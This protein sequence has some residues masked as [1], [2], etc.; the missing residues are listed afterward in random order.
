MADF[1][2]S[3]PVRTESNGDIVAKIGDKTTPSQQL[4]IDAAGLIGGKVY[5]GG[6]TAIGNNGTGAALNVFVTSVP[7]LTADTSTFTYAT[8]T[9]QVVGAVFQ[10]TGATIAAGK[11]GALRMTAQRG[12]HSNLR[13][14]SGNELL[15]SKVSASSVPVVVA[16]DNTLTVQDLAD[17][18]VAPG[19]V[20]TKSLLTGGQFNTTLPT[21][22]TG[23]QAAVQVDSSGRVLVAQPT[24]AALKATVNIQDGA[25]TAI[26]STGGAL[27]VNI[28]SGSIGSADKS[29][30]TYGTTQDQVVG[31][32]FQDTSP[33]LTA[34]QQGAIRLNAQRG[35]HTNL[36]D[37]SGNELL[38]QRT[39]ALSVPVVLA[40]DQL[41]SIAAG[42]NNIGKVSIQDSS[43]AVFGPLNP[44]PVY[45]QDSIGTEINNFNTTAALAGAASSN[46]D[47]T[48]TTGKVLN[49]FAVS[50]TGSGRMRMDIQVETGAATGVF[51]TVFVQFNSTATPNMNQL[52][53]ENI[54]VAAGV[55]VRVIRTNRDLSAQDVYST[56]Q[57]HE[58]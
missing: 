39:S 37:S 28:K 17:G 51:N 50:A 14:S 32:V 57:G 6:G 8:T 3:L 47:Y 44:L 35:L 9:D 56:I 5:D 40:S 41:V 1:N 36:R 26:T 42:T 24:A 7:G 15:G 46:H 31:G 54:R 48:V 10:D 23:Q 25:G 30:F 29:A 55:R 27:D 58:I 20:A 45:L 13:D 21:L 43:G 22:T 38:A 34:G 18:P 4:A 2:S 53:Q 49:L 12:L 16:S 33:T 11:Q 52:I 19:T